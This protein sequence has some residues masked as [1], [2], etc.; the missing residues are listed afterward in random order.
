M[1]QW[2]YLPIHIEAQANTKEMKEFLKRQMPDVKRFPRYMPQAMMPELNEL[3]AQ[4]WELVS[5]EPVA[6]VGSKADVYFNGADGKWSNVYFCV[7]KRRK[8]VPT[9]T[10]STPVQA[11]PPASPQTPTTES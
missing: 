9:Q 8:T 2:E 5:M 4:G 11:P 1:E 10:T 6:R 3:G 7:F